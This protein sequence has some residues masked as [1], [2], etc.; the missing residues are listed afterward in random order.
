M[1]NESLSI[2]E[3]A[4]ADVECELKKLDQQTS[5]AEASEQTIKRLED[6]IFSLHTNAGDLAPKARAAALT[7]AQAYLEIERADCAT[8]KAQ[9]DAQANRVVA[10]AQRAKS[11]LSQVWSALLEARKA[12]VE[13]MLEAKF[14]LVKVHIQASAL[15]HASREVIEI[16]ELQGSLFQ[17]RYL[18]TE[19]SLAIDDARQLRERSAGLLEMAVDELAE[20]TI[21]DVA[22]P[23]IVKAKPAPSSTNILGTM[24]PPVAA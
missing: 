16:A 11:L 20:L 6:D 7:N 21:I 1:T 23:P 18:P 2:V 15:S 22:L 19:R 9:V 5:N 3:S 10:F 13:A 4:L 8:L 14:D 12:S 24:A 17:Y